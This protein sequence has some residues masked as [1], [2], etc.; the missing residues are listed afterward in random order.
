MRRRRQVKQEVRS[1]GLSRLCV[2]AREGALGEAPGF[3]E[4]FAQKGVVEVL[5]Q[6][7]E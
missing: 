5:A 4:T 2:R 7:R 6:S 3:S 1:E